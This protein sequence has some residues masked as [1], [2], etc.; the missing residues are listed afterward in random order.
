[1]YFAPFLPAISRKPTFDY[2]Q[3]NDLSFFERFEAFTSKSLL[4]STSLL[5]VFKSVLDVVSLSLHPNIKAV[6]N[7]IK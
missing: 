3:I 4:I 7:I 6:N 2:K 5:L 1:M